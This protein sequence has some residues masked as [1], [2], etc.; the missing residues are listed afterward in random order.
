MGRFLRCKSS[1]HVA[2]DAARDRRAG[3]P[4]SG[5]HIPVGG[6]QSPTF[7]KNVHTGPS[8]PLHLHHQE[9]KVVKPASRPSLDNC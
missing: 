7:L 8:L 4:P 9:K 6:G 5:T 3:G 1:R 2:G